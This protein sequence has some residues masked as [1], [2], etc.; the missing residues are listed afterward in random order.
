MQ[1]I[2][3][4]GHVD[5]GKSALVRALTGMEPDRWAEERRRGMTIDLGFA[6][7][8]LPSGETLSFVDVPGHERFVPNMLAGVGAVPAACL[9]VAADEGWQPQ[10]EEHVRALDALGVAHGILVVTKADLADPSRV[11]DDVRRRLAAT[12]LRDVDAVAVSATTGNCMDALVAALDRLMAGMP[13]PHAGGPVRLWVDRVFTIQGAGTVV[14]GTLA[15]GSIAVGDALALVG[16]AAAGEVVVRGLQTHRRSRESAAAVD[17][18]AVNLRGVARADVSR[19]AALITPGAWSVTT[20]VDVRT[21]GEVAGDLVAHIGSAAVPVRPRPLASGV[22]RLR[23][24]QALPLH[25]G[26]RLLL[27]DPGSRRV[28]GATVLDVA[29]SPLRRRGDAARIAATLTWPRSVGDEITRCGIVRRADLVAAGFTD[30]PSTYGAVVAGGF[31]LSPH[32][33]RDRA[34]AVDAVVRAA[35]GGGIGSAELGA[36]TGVPPDAMTAVLAATDAVEV[37]LGRAVV[38][39][40][41][42]E[43]SEQLR[44]FL[45]R[46]AADPWAGLDG[47]GV[48]PAELSDAVRAGRVLRV[49]P[50]LYAAA[51]APARALA[52]L[53]ELPQP[54]TVS[55]ARQA[56]GSTRRVV[57]PL[58]EHLDATRRTTRDSD[59]KRFVVNSGA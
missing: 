53:A 19:G 12:T 46:L 35:A 55:E 58:L 16:P 49:A 36:Q 40:E 7:T 26:D 25:V 13:P 32:W 22:V 43:S 21:D 1:V 56:L 8:T 51:D 50:G 14:T 2:A 57:V 31:A 54:F 15:A 24:A 3:T 38:A 29:P 28:A 42:A 37:R 30:D 45:D 18:V 34:A 27:R 41:E 23:L 11:M 6:W 52:I 44:A 10:T 59:G 47:G 20:E 9:V 17:R 48:D 33:I 39:G 5:H 4:A